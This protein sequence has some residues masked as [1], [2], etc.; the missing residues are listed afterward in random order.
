MTTTGGEAYPLSFIDF[1]LY[2]SI[3][4][5]CFWAAAKVIWPKGIH[6]LSIQKYALAIE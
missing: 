6:T 5:F 1:T 2:L 3:I 4:A